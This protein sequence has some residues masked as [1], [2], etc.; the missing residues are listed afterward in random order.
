LLASALLIESGMWQRKWSGVGSAAKY[1][2]NIA[3]ATVYR[4]ICC[5]NISARNMPGL[6]YAASWPMS[7]WLYHLNAILLIL[8]LPQCNASSWLAG[9]IITNINII[10]TSSRLTV[11]VVLAFGWPIVPFRTGLLNTENI[12]TVIWRIE[13][14][15]WL[16]TIWRL[17]NEGGYTKQCLHAIC[18]YL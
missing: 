1:Q 15:A 11:A 12:L 5:N 6:I 18:L 10:S 14:M 2:L 8:I 4:N 9:Y 17:C 16:S 3:V 7:S 13:A